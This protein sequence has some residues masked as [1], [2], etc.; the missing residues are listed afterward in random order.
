MTLLMAKE[1]ENKLNFFLFV[2]RLLSG[3]QQQQQ[4]HIVCFPLIFSRSSQQKYNEKR[5]T[6][7]EAT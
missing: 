1:K 4:V 2:R 7:R 3:S 6:Y 5:K